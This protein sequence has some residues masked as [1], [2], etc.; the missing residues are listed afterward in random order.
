MCVVSGRRPGTWLMVMMFVID[1]RLVISRGDCYLDKNRYVFRFLYE[2]VFFSGAITRPRAWCGAAAG[3]FRMVG[4]R[5]RW[6]V[7]N[8]FASLAGRRAGRRMAYV[9]RIRLP[10]RMRRI[11][12]RSCLINP[13]FLVR[14]GVQ[15]CGVQDGGDLSRMLHDAR[16]SPPIRPARR[17][18]KCSPF[19]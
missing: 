6:F 8:G 14:C 5:M 18:Y 19:Y 3:F 10:L 9:F 16:T 4:F 17:E 2:T 12:V 13:F 7:L 11:A 15:D 1:G